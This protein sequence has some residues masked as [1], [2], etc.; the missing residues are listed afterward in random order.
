MRDL[1]LNLGCGNRPY[2]GYINVDKLALPGVQ[3]LCDLEKT[4]L[5]FSTDSISEINC[6]HILEHVVNFLPL[7]EEI[8]RISKPEAM[9]HVLAPYYRYE[10]AYRDPT[11]V[12]FFTEHSFDYL[13]DGVEFSFYSKARFRVEKVEKRVRFLSDVQ[14]KRKKRMQSIPNFIRPFLDHFLWD[15]YS[16][17]KFELKVLK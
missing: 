15:I 9:I 1:K 11:H 7:M 13:Q 10:G 8:H 16:E 5:P 6:E 2:V 17:L 4:P 14:D 3:V 12:R